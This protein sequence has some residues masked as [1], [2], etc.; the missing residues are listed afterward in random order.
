MPEMRP[1]VK[2]ARGIYAFMSV[3]LDF[4]RAEFWGSIAEI[5]RPETFVQNHT[6]PRGFF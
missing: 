2:N 1:K 4:R 3:L 5:R 6:S